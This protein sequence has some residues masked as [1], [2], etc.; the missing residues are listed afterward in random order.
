M[1]EMLS[2][3][4][5]PH[6]SWCNPTEEETRYLLLQGASWRV[7]LADKQDDIGR[8]ILVL[9]RHAGSLSDLDIAEWSELKM[10]IDR[11]E[12][13]VNRAFGATMCNW[14]CLMNDF[15]KAACPQPH[16]HLHLRPRYRSPVTVGLR[17]FRDRRFGHHYKNH[18]PNRLTAVERDEVFR[19]FKNVL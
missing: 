2:Q 16:L 4:M 17:K 3:G 9:N 12:A 13:A 19:R 14:S 5:Q 15:Y 10:I 18:R 11:L 6:C 1:N 7:Y 8:C